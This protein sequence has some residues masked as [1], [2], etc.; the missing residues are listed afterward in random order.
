[1]EL[2]RKW[3]EC[4]D[5]IVYAYQPI[6]NIHTGKTFGME[7]LMRRWEEAGFESISA[8]FQAAYEEK[9]LFPLEIALRHKALEQFVKIR[10]TWSNNFEF[11]NRVKLF[12]N[13]DN[14]TLEMPDY[15]SGGTEGLLAQWDLIPHDLVFEISEKHS[16]SSYIG[17][18]KVLEM[19]KGRGYG[20][21][22]DDFGS[23]Y[24]G[25]QLLYHSEPDIIK[26]DRFFIDN[27]DSDVKKHFFIANIVQMAH[28]IG[29]TVI[30]EGV[31]TKEEY[32]ACRE[33]GCDFV[34]GYFVQRPVTDY[35]D[36]QVRYSEISRLALKDH[37]KHL[38]NMPLLSERISKET[39]LPS[40]ASAESILDTLKRGDH[41]HPVR[42]PPGRQGL[43]IH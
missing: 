37:R 16:L 10:Q 40:D 42:I 2:P 30:A 22:V 35:S 20:I 8:L 39:A 26:I 18:N 3:Q 36:L 7:A 13:L 23:G 4:V 33:L 21:A 38:N 31:E 9:V 43:R 11:D 19:Y 1:M 41:H 15:F 25:L 6:V 27:I 28:M 29:S 14:R 12:F 5:T 32:Y 17:S 34:Q 24:A